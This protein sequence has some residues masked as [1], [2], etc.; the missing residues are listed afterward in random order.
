MDKEIKRIVAI[1][2]GVLFTVFAVIALIC[3]LTSVEAGE[4]VVK[5]SVS[6][7]LTAWNTAGIKFQ[8]FGSLT[9]YLK[10]D[11]Y[12]FRAT[13]DKDGKVT[14][15]KNCMSIRFNDQGKA[16][17]CGQ[18]SFDLPTDEVTM[19]KLHEKYRSL[20]GIEQRLIQPAVIKSIY[21][22]GPLMS[23]RESAGQKRGDL[24]TYIRE[25]ATR[26][27]YKTKSIET[28]VDDLTS[29]PI[30]IVETIEVPETD[31]NGKPKLD[32]DGKPIMK[33]EAQTVMRFRKKKVTVVEPIMKDGKIVVQ[34]VSPTLAYDIKI[35]NIT[36]D[37]IVY[38]PRVQ[39]Q[40]D[41]QRDM[42]MAVQTKI[43][44]A[45]Q[46]KQDAVTVE[47]KGKADAARA[48]WE[49]EKVK[50]QKVT[51]AEQKKAT[52]VLDLETAELQKKAMIKRAEGEA[53]SKKLVM[54]ADGNMD[55]KLK[56]LTEIARVNAEAV[57]KQRMVP[58]IQ[59]GSGG[60][61]VPNSIGLLN[62]LTAKAA[63][64]LSLDLSIKKN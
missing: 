26:G 9:T 21:N 47:Q 42:E 15:T 40:I 27:V 20:E 8:N 45:E 59:M 53:E 12:T 34:E 55:K 37:G 38:E 35:Y 22:S 50:A 24:I 13:K 2:G 17:I 32:E 61:G 41:K 33:T 57:S 23:S 14:S 64:D 51:E 36:I 31:E 30:P 6:G 63:K 58:E 54:N 18:L 46:A 60:S 25:Q 52:A 62:L 3:M 10:S 39:E 43:A 49:Q 1:I 7:E 5:Q 29:P 4:I 19:L 16:W 28:E 11:E 44:E 48:K 56:T